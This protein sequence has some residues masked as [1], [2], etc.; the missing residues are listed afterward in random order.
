MSSDMK[1]SCTTQQGYVE[2]AFVLLKR[3][4]SEDQAMA[5]NAYMTTACFW[6]LVAI[7]MQKEDE[8]L[9]NE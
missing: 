4:M 3:A 6:M 7:Y 2:N 8:V 1:P 5:I 9:P